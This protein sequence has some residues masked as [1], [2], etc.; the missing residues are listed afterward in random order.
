MSTLTKG[1]GGGG[2]QGRHDRLVWRK[3]AQ[4]LRVQEGDTPNLQVIDLA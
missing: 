4:V 3:V 2:G 1:G